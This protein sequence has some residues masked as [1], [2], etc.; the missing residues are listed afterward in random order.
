MEEAARYTYFIAHAGSDLARAR[1]LREL[2]APKLSVFLDAVDLQPGDT[3]DRLLP[4][5]QRQSRATVALLSAAVETA[6]YLREEI[7]SAIAY[8]R[9]DPAAHRLIPV[10]LDGVPKDPTGIPYGMRVLDHIDGA[11]GLPAVADRLLQM[12]SQ[13]AET[14]PPE[15]SP[16]TPAPADR[17]ALYDALCVLMPT[18]FDELLFRV[19][20]PRQHLAPASEPQARRALDLLQWAEQGG[21]ARLRTMDGAIQK[22][23]PGVLRR[24]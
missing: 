8:H 15:L 18:Q 9:Q 13:L 7:A 6:Y 1:E 23:A 11:T 5:Y 14:A 24:A 16:E 2:L 21:S 12:A 20:A 4:R 19:A 22:M 3:W 17:F 10:Y